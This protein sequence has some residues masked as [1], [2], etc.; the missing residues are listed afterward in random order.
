MRRL[1]FG[2]EGLMHIRI[3]KIRCDGMQTLA[4][5]SRPNLRR[6]DDNSLLPQ[7]PLRVIRTPTPPGAAAWLERQTRLPGSTNAANGWQVAGSLSRPT[8]GLKVSFSS[9]IYA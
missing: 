1:R 7:S 8:L 9:P 3:D 2:D 5:L 6:L 4:V